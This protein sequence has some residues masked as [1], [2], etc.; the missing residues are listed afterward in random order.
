MNCPVC[1]IPLKNVQYEDYS[2]DICIKC[3]GIWLDKGELQQVV[4][5]LISKNKVDYQTVKEAYRNKPMICKREEMPIRI[6]LKC[7][8]EMGT[9]NYYSDSDV[10]LDKCSSCGGIWADKNEI[11]QVAR[12]IKGNSQMDKYAEAL[13]RVYFRLAEAKAVTKQIAETSG[14]LV[15]SFNSGGKIYAIWYT[16]IPIPLRNDFP[17]EKFPKVTVGL[18]ILNS[19]IFILQLLFVTENQ[20]NYFKLVGVIPWLSFSVDRLFTF[21]SSIF[22]HGSLL[23]IIGNMYYL[24]LFGDNIEDE[25]GSFK[26]LIFYLLCGIIGGVVF[27]LMYSFLNEPAIGASGAISGVLGAYLLLYPKQGPEIAWLGRKRE[28]P[29]A[30]YLT[31]WII[32]QLFF[33]CISL[34]SKNVDIGY[35]AHIGGFISGLLLIRFFIVKKLSKS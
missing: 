27:C 6:C 29:A 28:I 2:V 23:H 18:I 35:W 25:I 24:W 3:K 32:M 19:L 13:R 5:E 31:L 8:I 1:N 22:I 14:D 7:N 17:T 11:D 4:N 12:Y 16:I 9:F 15:G 33:G 20:E 34:A 30:Y 26:F 10:F 21:I